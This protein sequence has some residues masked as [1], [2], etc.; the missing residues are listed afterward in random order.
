MN[1][2]KHQKMTR[3]SPADSNCCRKCIKG[4]FERFGFI[5]VIISAILLGII[6]ISLIIIVRLLF[7]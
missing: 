3:K 2:V 5:P 7:K 6:L 4:L 1:K